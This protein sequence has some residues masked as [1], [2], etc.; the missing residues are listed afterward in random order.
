MQCNARRSGQTGGGNAQQVPT[1]TANMVTSTGTPPETTVT[2]NGQ[3]FTLVPTTPVQASVNTAVTVPDVVF[4]GNVSDYDAA[5]STFSP[6]V[7]IALAPASITSGNSSFSDT[8]SESNT[9]SHHDRYEYKAYIA[10]TGSSHTSVDWRTNSNAL[11]PS[12]TT[13]SPITFTANHA[14]MSHMGSIP[15]IL[16]SGANCHISPEC[17]DFK[18]LNAIP[19][20]TVKGFGGSSI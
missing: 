14:P 20:L 2:I 11:E 9:M 6:S 19:P 3:T 8:D 7:N 16:D 15:F 17:G 5:L 18:S 12:A 4:S 1:A 10:L 13:V